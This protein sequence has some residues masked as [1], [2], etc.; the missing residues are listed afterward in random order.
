MPLTND[1]ASNPARSGQPSVSLSVAPATVAAGQSATASW[2]ATL[3]G[4][5]TLSGDLI[6]S[7]PEGGTGTL[8]VSTASASAGS[9]S[10]SMSC[11][12]E[13]SETGKGSTT[14]AVTAASS[15]SSSS[16]GGGSSSSSGGSPLCPTPKLSRRPAAK[17]LDGRLERL[18]GPQLAYAGTGM[19][20]SSK[21][22]RM[23]FSTC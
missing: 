19:E 3:T 14:L 20:F 5:C 11:V 2:S 8:I 9:Y 16:S 12:S 4:Q 7:Q 13:D 6:A 21:N 22:C 1:G 15:S 17:R 23:G 10:F 18:V